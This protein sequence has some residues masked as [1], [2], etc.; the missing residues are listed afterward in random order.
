[1]LQQIGHIATTELQGAKTYL[2]AYATF[3]FCRLNW[4]D[5]LL[6]VVDKV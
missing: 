2:Q 6:E 3:V 1:M 5:V 4:A